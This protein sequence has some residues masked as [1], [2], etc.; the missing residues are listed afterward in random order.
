M[1]VA[2]DRRAGGGDAER[3]AG[4]AST[5]PESVI[6]ATGGLYGGGISSDHHGRLRETVFGLPRRRVPAG[7]AEWFRETFLPADH[8]IHYAGVAVDSAMRPVDEEGQVL[9]ENLRVVG[10][11]AGRVQWPVRGLDRRRLD[12]DRYSAPYLRYNDL[13]RL[14]E[15]K[16]F[17][18]IKLRPNPG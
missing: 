12:R 6:L 13:Q 8:P 18:M 1:I 17:A 3:G 7:M 15:D 5:G 4:D 10:R 2:G 11:A 9:F 14:D 16:E